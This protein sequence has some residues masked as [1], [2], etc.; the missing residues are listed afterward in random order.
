MI[1]QSIQGLPNGLPSTHLARHLRIKEGCGG[2]VLTSMQIKGLQDLQTLSACSGLANA[3]KGSKEAWAAFCDQT[4]DMPLPEGW[5][6]KTND[7]ATTTV[8]DV[9][10]MFWD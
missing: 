3:M 1:S 4:R 7:E 5:A 8:R 9:L 6:P 2:Q 10:G